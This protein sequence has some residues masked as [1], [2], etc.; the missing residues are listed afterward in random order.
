MRFFIIILFSTF[1]F[2]DYLYTRTSKCVQSYWERFDENGSLVG[3]CYS[4]SRD[5]QGYCNR[6][7]DSSVFKY[8]YSYDFSDDSCTNFSDDSNDSNS[9]ADSESGVLPSSS[10]Y[11]LEDHIYQALL[12]L[13]GLFSSMAFF[14][15]VFR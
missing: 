3:Y 14:S 11:G 13:L 2:S 12:G 6:N 1:L 15:K 9:T 4:L 7:P 10:F 5:G 8:G